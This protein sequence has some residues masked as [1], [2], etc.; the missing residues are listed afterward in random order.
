MNTLRGITDLAERDGIDPR[1]VVSNGPSGPERDRILE[2]LDEHECALLRTCR[3]G[4]LTGSALVVDPTDRRILLLFHAKLQRWLQPGGHADGDGDLA[5]GA[6][7][8]AGEETGIAGL[9]VLEPPVDLDV[10]V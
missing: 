7:R 5:R 6:L 3:P 9:R 4:H 2:L 8:E 1:V 10:H